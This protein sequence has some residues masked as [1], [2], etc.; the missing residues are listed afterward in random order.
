MMA[1]SFWNSEIQGASIEELRRLQLKLLQQQ[2]HSVYENSRFY[3]EKFEKTGLKPSDI[4]S[5]RDIVKIPLTTREE[6]EQSYLDILAVPY[7]DVAT[8][9]LSSGTTGHPLRVAYTKKDVDMIAEASARR[10][11]Y[12]GVTNKDVVQITSA[13]GLW[14]GAWS[15]HWGAEKMGV[16]VIP[17]RTSRYR[18]ADSLDKAVWNHR[19]LR[20]NELPFQNT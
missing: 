6:L 12:H 14:Q 4:R 1:G 3:R 17:R 11:A 7:Y 16:C 18:K 2:M 5:L 19:S 9:R 8:I 10:L 20:D 15:M 13:Y